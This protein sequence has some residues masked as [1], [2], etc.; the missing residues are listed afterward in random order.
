[1]NEEAIRKFL[2][3]INLASKQPAQ[4]SDPIINQ[5]INSGNQP[6]T[7]A[8]N[9]RLIQQGLLSPEYNAAGTQLQEMMDYRN[10]LI[11]QLDNANIP[12]EYRQMLMDELN[13]LN[14][15]MGQ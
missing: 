5:L 15:F 6:M 1:M 11:M 12:P 14:S 8:D 3:S 2:Q 4:S 10:N 9:L 13:N 7:N